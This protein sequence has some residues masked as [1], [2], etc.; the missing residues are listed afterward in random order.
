MEK[1]IEGARCIGATWYYWKRTPD[2]LVKAF[3]LPEFRRESMKTKDPDE[4][5]RLARAYLTELDELV[6]KL[7]SVSA[8]VRVYGDLSDRERTR[9]DAEIAGRVTALPADQKQKIRK[10]GGV[11]GAG[12]EMVA[13]EAS[14][15]FMEAG[16][17]ADYALK[18]AM[19]EEYDPDERELEEVQEGARVAL[20]QKKGKAL[21]DALTAAKIIE[22][23]A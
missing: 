6:R 14:A 3:G 4:A 13:Q 8:R 15:A 11:W 9:L 10:A 19:G 2:R 7:D 1:S 21:G 20:H 16:L 17:G 22:P 12:R 23:T 18:D 5:A